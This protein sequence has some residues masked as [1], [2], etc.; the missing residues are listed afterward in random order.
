VYVVKALW[1]PLKDPARE[2][3]CGINK[4][5]HS[6]CTI[7]ESRMSSFSITSVVDH[8]LVHNGRCRLS[9]AFGAFLLRFS[10]SYSVSSYL[11]FFELMICKS[12]SPNPPYNS[13]CCNVRQRFLYIVIGCSNK[14]KAASR[15]LSYNPETLLNPSYDPS[16]AIIINIHQPGPIFI[17]IDLDHATPVE[18]NRRIV[19]SHVRSKFLIIP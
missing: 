6:N 12:A 5:K 7:L 9:P 10:R 11:S 3:K 17:W 4:Y 16:H 13:E 15:S 8:F 14:T 1:L 19:K 2:R 18:I